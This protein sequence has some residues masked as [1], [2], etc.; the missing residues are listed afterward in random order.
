MEP[1]SVFIAPNGKLYK[2]YKFLKWNCTMEIEGAEETELWDSAMKGQKEDAVID[3]LSITSSSNFETKC[4]NGFIRKF[5]GGKPV[6]I[7]IDF[8]TAD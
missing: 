1:G 7:R 3:T 2:W 4:P 5:P 6:A 8:N